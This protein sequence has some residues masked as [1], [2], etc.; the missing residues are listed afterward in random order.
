VLFIVVSSSVRLWVRLVVLAASLAWGAVLL[1][2]SPSLF[3]PYSL[4]LLVIA[5][6]ALGITVVVELIV[7]LIARAIEGAHNRTW[8][9]V[10][11]WIGCL[12]VPFALSALADTVSHAAGQP[13]PTDATLLA[14]F[15]SFATAVVAGARWVSRQ[16]STLNPRYPRT[17]YPSARAARGIL[18]GVAVLTAAGYLTA[19][20]LAGRVATARTPELVSEHV[21]TAPPSQELSPPGTFRAEVDRAISSKVARSQSAWNDGQRQ[22]AMAV[23]E[24]RKLINTRAPALSAADKAYAH[25]KLASALMGRGDYGAAI[26]EVMEAVALEP[27]SAYYRNQLAWSLCLSGRYKEALPHAR[28]AAARAPRDA[29]I[30]DTR[31]HAAYGAAEWEDAVRAWSNTLRIK[32][33]FFSDPAHFDCEEDIAHYEEAKR[34]IAREAVQPR[35]VPPAAPLPKAPPRSG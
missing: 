16:R 23:A 24:C 13:R 34:R 33:N 19:F 29:D 2:N 3:L 8:V 11:G 27:D 21:F 12:G 17:A 31:A 9:V 32:P 10:W 14:Y 28:V 35:E 1:T 7:H 20:V 6:I 26:R 30:W 4:A 25:G 15:L 22:W 18:A 5:L